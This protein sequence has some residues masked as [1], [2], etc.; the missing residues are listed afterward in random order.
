MD[1]KNTM[2]ELLSAEKNA[3]DLYLHGSIESGTQNVN[4]A[5]TM[6][7]QDSLTLQ[8]DLY[9][10]MADKGWYTTQ[11]A[12]QQQMQQVKQKYSSQSQSQSQSQ[13]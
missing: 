12:P 5:F 13:G 10:K 3:C 2:Q 8:G 6:A 9:K 11:Q 7:L 4:Q 1:D